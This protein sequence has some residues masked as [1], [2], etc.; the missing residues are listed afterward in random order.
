MSY[1]HV[2]L[3]ILDPIPR[4]RSDRSYSLRRCNSCRHGCLK[5]S[6]MGLRINTLQDI[7]QVV[8]LEV[9]SWLYEWD[10]VASHRKAT[11]A[12]LIRYSLRTAFT[13]SGVRW[14]SGT[15]FVMLIPP[16]SFLLNVMLGGSLLSR[17]PNPSNSDSMIFLWVRGLLTSRTIKIKLHVLATAMT[18]RPRP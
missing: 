18:W 15:V 4:S 6:T 3:C 9:S 10:T 17:M 16:F 7:N 13:S 14:V 2:V 11:S 8:N 5:V 12:L 1:P